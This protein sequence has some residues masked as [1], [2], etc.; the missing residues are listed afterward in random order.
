MSDVPIKEYVDRRFEDQDKAVQA[1]LASAE[2]AVVTARNANDKRF[3]AANEVKAT[4]SEDL[5][6]KLDRTEYTSNHKSLEDK[7]DA[8]T[9]RMN[10][11][12]GHSG[13]LNAGWG[14]LVGAIGLLGSVVGI[15]IGTR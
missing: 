14:Y 15:I 4:F 2:K 8:L 1:A 9:D 6:R 7:I 3:E 11:N 10:R 12:E 5:A 13:G